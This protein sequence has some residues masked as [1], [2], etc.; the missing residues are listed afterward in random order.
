[1][2][3][4]ALKSRT[5]RL[6]QLNGLAIFWRFACFPFADFE[7]NSH[8]CRATKYT[9]IPGARDGPNVIPH[10]GALP[11]TVGIR[12]F[13]MGRLFAE[14]R[15]ARVWSSTKHAFARIPDCRETALKLR[16][17]SVLHHLRL[18]EICTGSSCESSAWG[19]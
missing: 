8:Q 2:R 4:Q 13:G 1:M 3:V 6:E 11:K 19:V 18:R 14:G 16:Y 9:K 17:L 10:F 5:V 15:A 7:P 12:S